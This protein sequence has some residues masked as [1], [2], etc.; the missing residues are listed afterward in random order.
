[1]K[2]FARTNKINKKDFLSC[3][4]LL[5]GGYSKIVSNSSTCQYKLK[6]TILN[7]SKT[8]Y[9]NYKKVNLRNASHK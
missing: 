4:K 5:I 3:W 7:C 6:N 8:P 1:M 9:R 2:E